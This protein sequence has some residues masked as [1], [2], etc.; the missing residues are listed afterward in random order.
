[1][2]E[3]GARPPAD[4]PA[5][6]SFYQYSGDADFRALLEGA[7]LEEVR[8]STVSFSHHVDDLDAFWTDLLA[9]TVR[10][11]V[12]VTSQTPEVQR[13]LRDA[14]GRILER[15]R[16]PNGLEVPCSVKIGSGARP[17]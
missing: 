8:V 10:T 13:Q 17:A 6:P 5:G 1:M 12:L 7:G 11:T 3:V 14:W 9:G 15:H 2:A 4:L 16:G